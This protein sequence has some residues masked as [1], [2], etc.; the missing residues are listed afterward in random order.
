MKKKTAKATKSKGVKTIPSAVK[1]VKI[2]SA[3]F[4]QFQTLLS[5]KREEILQTVK[6]KEQE[7]SYGEIGD[8]A[9]VASQTF[10]REMIF[11]LNNGERMILDDIEAALRRLEKNNFGGCESCN[12][13]ISDQRLRA[14]PWARYCIHCQTRTESP[15][16]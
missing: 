1:K 11:E 7:I 3:Q 5:S 10:E 2:S 15:A 16:A 12:K 8:E 4:K 9:D 13:K 6:Q 14:M